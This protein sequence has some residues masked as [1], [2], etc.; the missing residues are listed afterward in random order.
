MEAPGHSALASLDGSGGLSGGDVTGAA[1]VIT[2]GGIRRNGISQACRA[3]AP[4]AYSY[5]ASIWPSSSTLPLGGRVG[6]RF[7]VSL[8]LLYSGQVKSWWRFTPAAAAMAASVAFGLSSRKWTARCGAGQLANSLQ[9]L[10][11]TARAA[12]GSA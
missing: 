1:Q 4:S 11:C 8:A 6:Q 3:A 7:T 12:G 10:T 5:Q 2:P 9:D